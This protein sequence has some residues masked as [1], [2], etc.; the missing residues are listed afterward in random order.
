MSHA[1]IAEALRAQRE[2]RETARTETRGNG[3]QTEPLVSSASGGSGRALC[4][5]RGRASPAKTNAINE[6]DRGA[7]FRGRRS[8]PAPAG[9]RRPSPRRVASEQSAPSDLRCCVAPCESYLSAISAALRSL[10]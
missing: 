4:A 5:R 7:R 2:H 3:G 10:R 9:G 6:S 8:S 1:E